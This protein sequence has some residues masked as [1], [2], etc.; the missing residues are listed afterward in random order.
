MKLIS[1]PIPDLFVL[2]PKVFDDARGYFFEAFNKRAFKD[3]GLDLDFIQDNESCSD[4]GVIRGLHFQLSPYAQTKLVRVISGKILDVALDLR[5]N[6]PTFGKHFSIE[7]DSDE[8]KMLLIPRGF[9]HGFSVL[10][11]KAIVV[12]K[13]DSLYNPDADRGILFNDPAIGIDWKVDPNKAIVSAKD[14]V[15]PTLKEADLNFIYSK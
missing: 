3:L 2:E 10:S 15:H 4:Y 11:P 5:K 8:K 6:S 7:L 13:C 1:T 14:R 9:A 12:Y